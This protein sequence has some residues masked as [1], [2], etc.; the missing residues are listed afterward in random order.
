MLRTVVAAIFLMC[1]V[2]PVWASEPES[3]D[4]DQPFE[5]AL[6]MNLLRSLFDQAL[7]RLEDH[8][9]ISGNLNPNEANGDEGKHLRFKFYPEGK[10][11]SDEH[12]AAEGWFH[13]SPESGQHDWHFKF[14]RPEDRRQKSPPQL[15]APL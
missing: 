11:K 9:E 10:S 1:M 15:K 2:A 8:V 3:F 14:K 6:N 13:S 4:P 5:Q 12:F 7:D